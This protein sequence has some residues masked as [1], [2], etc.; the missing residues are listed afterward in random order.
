MIKDVKREYVYAFAVLVAIGLLVQAGVPVHAQ[1]EPEFRVQFSFG[2]V[3]I[4]G[5][6]VDGSTGRRIDTGK[7]T[8]VALP[9]GATSLTGVTKIRVSAPGYRPAYVRSFS[10]V[11]ARFLFFNFTVIDIGRVVL[12][13]AQQMNQAPKAAFDYSPG[14][15]RPGRTVNFDASGSYDPDGYLTSYRWDFNG[16]GRTDARG[17]YVNFRFS[18]SG[19]YNVTLRVMDN[20]GTSSSVTQTISVTPGNQAP[21]A[22]FSYSPEVPRNG[23]RVSFNASGSYDPDGFIRSYRWD[24]DGDGNTDAGGQTADFVFPSTGRYRVV[25][26]VEDSYGLTS[27]TARY[28][29][30]VP[31]QPSFFSSNSNSFNSNGTRS[32]NHY[33]LRGGNDYA[34]WRWNSLNRRP[35]NAFLNLH[36]LVSNRMN[37]GSGFEGTVEIKI[38]NNRGNVIETGQVPLTNPF[39]PRYSGDTGGTGYDA[40][41][42]YEIRNTGA[43]ASGFTVEVGPSRGGNPFAVNNQSITLAWTG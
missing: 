7:V 19:I 30:V 22:R 27:S 3:G 17:R 11:T 8:F 6:I 4:D 25:L 20:D 12:H 28:V 24:F 5:M 31:G 42:T 1:R 2:T 15:P 36:F 34:E 13:P 35:Q 16:D 9:G 29:E 18:S 32:D 39:R 23:E 33:W 37:G 26:T 40:Y 14:N 38:I 21:V 41:G 43:I 10:R